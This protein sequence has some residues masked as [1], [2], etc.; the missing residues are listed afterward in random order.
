[1]HHPF[2][3]LAGGTYPTRVW[4]PLSGECTQ[5]SG[6]P[7]DI[8]TYT[9]DSSRLSVVTSTVLL[10]TRELRKGCPM[11]SDSRRHVVETGSNPN[12]PRNTR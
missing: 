1:M 9:R 6:E 4:Q 11:S 12:P 8:E 3:R 10:G 2:A 7:D 5:K